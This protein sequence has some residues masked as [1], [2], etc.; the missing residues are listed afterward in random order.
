MPL[1]IRVRVGMR[2]SQ[3]V[4]I[5]G[6]GEGHRERKRVEAGVRPIRLVPGI[7]IARA[8]RDENGE[9][10][11]TW[12]HDQ[13]RRAGS[14]RRRP[15]FGNHDVGR[16]KYSAVVS[17]QHRSQQ[18]TAHDACRLFKEVYV[19][20][21]GSFVFRGKI[22][23]VP[24]IVDSVAAAPPPQPFLLGILVGVHDRPHAHGEQTIRLG[25]VDHVELDHRVTDHS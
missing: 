6:V 1:V 23:V 18:G 7:S 20:N 12:A 10:S 17:R 15:V 25:E 8:G 5:P 9:D 11:H 13:P 16:M 14:I 3:A 21:I 2:V 19:H 22:H 4:R 24:A